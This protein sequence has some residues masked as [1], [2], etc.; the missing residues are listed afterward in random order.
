MPN[1]KVIVDEINQDQHTQT[2]FMLY[3]KINGQASRVD[4]YTNASYNDNIIDWTLNTNDYNTILNTCDSS[5]GYLV[6]VGDPDEEY[7]FRLIQNIQYY[8]LTYNHP[9]KVYTLSEIYTQFGEI[10][11]YGVAASSSLR[12]RAC[13]KAMF[14]Q[15]FV[16]TNLAISSPTSIPND[17]CLKYNSI[18]KKEIIP[19]YLKIFIYNNS[20]FTVTFS[21]KNTTSGTY[22]TRT[23]QPNQGMVVN[24]GNTNINI[25]PGVLKIDQINPSTSISIRAGKSTSENIQ[26][27]QY[28][29]TVAEGDIYYID[30]IYSEYRD[31]G[32]SVLKTGDTWYLY[33]T[34]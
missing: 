34:Y 29:G 18:Y 27:Y 2:A 22:I 14:N 5:E 33:F 9:N 11:L 7:K 4:T 10:N 30:D 24:T 23:G 3:Q 19:D 16:N 8:S 28:T 1:I 32:G 17:K 12:A 13:T 20:Q 6:W 31:A 25:S 21:Y 26:L 15:Y